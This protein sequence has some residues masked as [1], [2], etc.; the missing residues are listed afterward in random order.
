MDTPNI[1]KTP[2]VALAYVPV[3]AGLQWS[4]SY[5]VGCFV[6]NR[7]VEP[8]AFVCSSV[9]MVSAFVLALVLRNTQIRHLPTVIYCMVFVAL[10]GAALGGQF[11][12]SN[13]IHNRGVR[14]PRIPPEITA[15]VIVSMTFG[16]QA[17]MLVGAVIGWFVSYQTPMH[18]PKV[19]SIDHSMSDSG[20]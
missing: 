1:A 17:G 9:F 19:R 13:E 5:V 4:A 12:T 3:A 7:P 15:D 16:M 6:C 10:F 2:L 18:R 20:N 11:A 8:S 14:L